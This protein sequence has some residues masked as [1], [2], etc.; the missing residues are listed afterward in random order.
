[1]PIS[2]EIFES[3]RIQERAAE[4]LKA[5]NLLV[6]QGYTVL[7]LEGNI[8]NRTTIDQFQDS[9]HNP[10]PRYDYKRKPRHY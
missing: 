4:Q 5:I 6:A 9:Y 7:D 3:Y 1:M 8:I 10:R 2:N